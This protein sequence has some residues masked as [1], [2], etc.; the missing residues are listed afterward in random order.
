MNDAPKDPIVKL[1]GDAHDEI[2]AAAKAYVAGD[3]AAAA[4][5]IDDVAI[6]LRDLVADIRDA[7]AAEQSA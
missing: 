2:L 1:L 4:A 6:G 7:T 3:P 5:A